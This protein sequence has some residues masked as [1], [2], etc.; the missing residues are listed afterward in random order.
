MRISA[1][2]LF[3]SLALGATSCGADDIVGYHF[4]VSEDLS[5]VLTVRSLQPADD[6][7]PMESGAQGVTFERRAILR[8]SSGSFTDLNGIVL[9]DVRITASKRDG[10][11]PRLRVTIPRGADAAWVNHIA[12]TADQQSE[13]AKTFDATGT[14]SKVGTVVKF[15]IVLPRPV[16]STG[17][18][19]RARGVQFEKEGRTATLLFPVATAR[20][21]GTPVIWDVTWE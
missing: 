7:G 12:P 19:P 15:E 5:G 11:A 8:S 16:V 9:D 17:A 14:A 3:L 20:T 10:E 18:H 1:I 4:D 21:A 2:V 6:A 13:V